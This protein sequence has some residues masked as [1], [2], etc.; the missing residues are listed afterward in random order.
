MACHLCAYCWDKYAANYQPLPVDSPVDQ[1]ADIGTCEQC[2]VH[3]CSVHSQ[4]GTAFHCAYCYMGATITVA[5]VGTP[6]PPGS[7]LLYTS[8]SPRDS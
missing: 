8:P 1:H 2:S 7:C 6:S 3:A 5:V 4:Y